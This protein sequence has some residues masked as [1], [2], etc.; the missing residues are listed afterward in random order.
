MLVWQVRR[1]KNAM[2][3][4]EAWR[5]REVAATASLM[6]VDAIGRTIKLYEDDVLDGEI[7][8]DRIAELRCVLGELQ[9]V[10][11]RCLCFEPDAQVRSALKVSGEL[12]ALY[13]EARCYWR[14]PDELGGLPV[15]AASVEVQMAHL[16]E[17]ISAQLLQ[18]S[19]RQ[20]GSRNEQQCMEHL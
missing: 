9:A 1:T 13:N 20:T 5:V 16:A 10:Q 4:K 7:D 19:E 15:S 18:V 3:P 6:V 14:V 12:A 8:N 17:T 11:M 2:S